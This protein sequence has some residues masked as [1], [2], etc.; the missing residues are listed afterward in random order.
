LQ[1]LQIPVASGAGGI[2]IGKLFNKT[3][4]RSQSTAGDNQMSIYVQGN[5][6]QYE[7]ESPFNQ[8]SMPGLMPYWP[9]AT[10]QHNLSSQLR[11]SP[12]ASGSVLPLRPLH[13][14]TETSPAGSSLSL[15]TLFSQYFMNPISIGVFESYQFLLIQAMFYESNQIDSTHKVHILGF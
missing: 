8:F 13:R 2:N 6:R 3:P 11:Q 14:R 15:S 7:Y 9:V 10:P 4:K 1:L 12:L 5:V